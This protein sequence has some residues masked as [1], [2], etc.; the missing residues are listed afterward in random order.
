[1]SG[2]YEIDFLKAVTAESIAV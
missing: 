2:S 1:M